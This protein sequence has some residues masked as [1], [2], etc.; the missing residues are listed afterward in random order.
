M[1]HQVELVS[2]GKTGDI[3]AGNSR[4]SSRPAMSP[5]AWSLMK[6]RSLDQS[7]KTFL[8]I[9]F[10]TKDGIRQT[11]CEQARLALQETDCANISKHS[12]DRPGL[13]NSYES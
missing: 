5:M 7:C 13:T 12:I 3:Q 6:D 10:K 2:T 9:R 8:G 1:A 4:V 11:R